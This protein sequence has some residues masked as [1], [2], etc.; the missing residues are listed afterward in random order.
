M[1]IRHLVTFIKHMSVRFIKFMSC[2]NTERG[3]SSGALLLAYGNFNAKRNKIRYNIPD[4]PKNDNGLTQLIR[5]GKSFRH[6]QVKKVEG[7]YC[8]CEI[9]DT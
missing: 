2:K 3:V 1:I 8:L 9:K 6:I 5:M 4:F 7:L